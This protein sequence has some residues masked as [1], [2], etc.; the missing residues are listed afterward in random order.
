M[1]LR[2]GWIVDPN[3]EDTV[4]LVQAEPVLGCRWCE[5]AGARVVLGVVSGFLVPQRT[6]SV[7]SS[8]GT[9]SAGAA[10]PLHG[11]SLPS[12]CHVVR[13]RFGNLTC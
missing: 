5:S 1:F 4:V 2:K 10:F 11:S 12:L 6:G 3:P 9:S 13:M 7:A 8:T